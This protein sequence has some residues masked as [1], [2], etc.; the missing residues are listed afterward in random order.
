[1]SKKSTQ[2]KQRIT[3][4]SIP[5]TITELL[6]DESFLLKEFSSPAH[7][8]ELGL[9]LRNP[10]GYFYVLTCERSL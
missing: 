1:M 4:T 9:A 5:Q 2:S 10:I 7:P 3:E 6:L 8:A